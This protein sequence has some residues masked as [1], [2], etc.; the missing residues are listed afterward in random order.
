M[1]SSVL[2]SSYIVPFCLSCSGG[3]PS[4]FFGIEAVQY[5]S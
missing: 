5:E 3:Y 1:L 4:D 2:L